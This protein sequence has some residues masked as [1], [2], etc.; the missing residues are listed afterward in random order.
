[1]FAL[2]FCSS[3]F[4]ARGP[5]A[6]LVLSLVPTLACGGS[7]PMEQ[8]DASP[9][10]A[11]VT[12]SNQVV[13]L[14]QDHC[15]SCHRPEGLAPFPLM[16]YDDAKSRASLLEAA[17]VSHRMPEGMPVRI[18]TGC[19]DPETFLGPRRLSASE[20]EIF[21]TWAIEGMPEGDAS[22]LPPPRIFPDGEWVM[23]QPDMEMPNCTGG[24]RVP[25]TLQR[26]VFRRF[27]IPTDLASDQYITGF[28]AIPGTAGGTG[29]SHIVHHVTLFVAPA[30]PALQRESAYAA[31][32]PE[33]PGPGFEGDFGFDATLVGMWFPG[34]QPLQLKNG[35]GIRLPQGAALIAEVHYSPSEETIIDETRIGLLLADQVDEELV[36]G[37]VKNEVFTVPAQ[38][39]DF[40]VSATKVF[41]A[42]ATLYS[43]TPHM[44]QLGT[45]FKV[46]INRPDG[47]TCL[48][49]VE[50]D[51]EHQGTYWLRE[52]M[53]LP[54]GSS[55]HTTCRYDN[56]VD[57]P[58]QYN[59]PPQD[60]VFGAVADRE[61]CQLTVGLLANDSPAASAP[62][63]VEVLYDA[64][65]SDDTT[66]WIKL[67][68]PSAT[69]ID[70]ASYSIGWGGANYSYGRL[71]L[72][73]TLPA[74]SCAVVGAPQAGALGFAADFV[75]NLQNAETSADGIALFAAL[76]Q[77]ISES[78][79]PIDSV[80][81]GQANDSGLIDASGAA[82]AVD[83]GNAAPGLSI[84]RDSTTWT[85]GE[86]SPADCP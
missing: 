67:H 8:P 40:E 45:D 2:P 32:S 51:F 70:L 25:N 78:S 16:T 85:T 15:Q 38:N 1:M 63:L 37:L 59:F 18:D 39:A 61:M 12:Y 62:R 73:G 33:V 22:D 34:S 79:V 21:S 71:Q 43:I 23:G 49:D 80:V 56:S 5:L 57:N 48:A 6:L 9:P 30:A 64:V 10:P 84:R 7:D 31:S 53:D 4:V 29:L 81:Y 50:W 72:A 17:V 66:E 77:D 76:A 82:S 41:D 44:H 20:I 26:D 27:V 55:I 19:S 68:N 42:P 54:A 36:V 24:F 60:I 52:P 11:S 74:N 58:N 14:L 28:E 86:P 46:M 3:H 13:R 69:P 65:G 75:P 35:L 47:E 83:V